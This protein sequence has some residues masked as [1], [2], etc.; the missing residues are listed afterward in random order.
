MTM[1]APPSLVASAAEG[2]IMPKRKALPTAAPTRTA[3][4]AVP[5]ER[6]P[7]PAQRLAPDIS[8]AERLIEQER[9]AIESYFQFV[10][11]TPMNDME[12]TM[13]QIYRDVYSQAAKRMLNTHMIRLIELRSYSVHKPE[14]GWRRTINS[15]KMGIILKIHPDKLSVLA[16]HR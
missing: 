7:A 8:D 16:G 2:A 6:E 3:V 1:K 10:T 15:F 13:V 9:K 4:P 11:I 5:C 14:D 12:R